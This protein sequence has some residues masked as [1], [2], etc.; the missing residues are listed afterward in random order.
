LTTGR[1]VQNN[2]GTCAR[3]SLS[4]YL[5]TILGQDDFP[6]E[7]ALS[8]SNGPCGYLSV[9]PIPTGDF[10]FDAFLDLLGSI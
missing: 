7:K 10:D 2:N 6:V 8:F 1:P 4:N 9:W 3:G 5:G